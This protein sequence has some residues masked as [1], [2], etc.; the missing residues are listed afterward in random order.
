MSDIRDVLDQ[1]AYVPY[2]YPQLIKCK[3][4]SGCCSP[5]IPRC[6]KVPCYY[7]DH[8]CSTWGPYF[9]CKCPINPD[10]PPFSG[11]HE[12]LSSMD[13]YTR[14]ADNPNRKYPFPQFPSSRRYPTMAEKYLMEDIHDC[15]HV[16]PDFATLCPE[17]RKE[18]NLLYVCPYKGSSHHNM[19]MKNVFIVCLNIGDF[20]AF[21]LERYCVRNLCST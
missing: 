18:F 20:S 1:S 21:P 3:E 9:R 11:V 12:E 6:P 8:W 15:P 10:Y 4:L 17:N 14:I 16:E 5:C 2:N 13:Y 19:F 7:K